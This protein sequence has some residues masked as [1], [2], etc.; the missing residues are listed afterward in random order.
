[1]RKNYLKT[2]SLILTAV[3]FL[4]FSSVVSDAQTKRKATTRKPALR[5]RT[6]AT[7]TTIV[8]DGTELKIRLNDE[9]S[10]KTA[11]VGDRFTATVLNPTRYEEAT[12]RGHISSIRKSGKVNG[13]TTMNLAF[14]SIELREGRRGVMHGQ[15]IRVYGGE[16]DQVD[17]EGQVKSGSRGKQTLK[18]SGIGAAAGAILGGIIGGGKGAA[19]GL[20]LGGAGGAGSLY[21]EGSKELKLESGT[22][23]LIRVTRR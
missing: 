4:G 7:D 10:S 20:I 21:V 8:A 2:V 14:D 1:M 15:L 12:V 9:L 11:R 6:A 5:S 18:R 22:E 23:M 17:E 16:S 19:I 13:R 3:F